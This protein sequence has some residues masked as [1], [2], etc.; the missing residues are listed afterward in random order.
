MVYPEQHQQIVEDLM[1]G[2][3]ILSKEK[4]FASLTKGESFY[5]QFFKISFGYELILKK[6]YAYIVSED[7]DENISRDISIFFAILCYELDKE[8]KNFLDD[9]QYSEF[10]F[11]EVNRLLENSSYYEL[12]QTNKQLKDIDARRRL[13]YSTMYKKNIIEKINDDRFFFTSAYKVFI[14]F[15][16]ELGSSKLNETLLD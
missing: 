9:L 6:E 15:A 11:E 5:S 8:G 14:D 4:H 2:K 10:S 3:F 7:T 1:N 12:M 16:I 13:L